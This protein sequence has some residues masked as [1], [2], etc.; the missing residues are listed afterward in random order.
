MSDRPR[1]P[2]CGLYLIEHHAHRCGVPILTAAAGVELTPIEQQYVRWLAQC[3]RETV[4]VFAGLFRRCRGI[5][6]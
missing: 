4:D 3:D 1:C 5:S 6:E 2:E